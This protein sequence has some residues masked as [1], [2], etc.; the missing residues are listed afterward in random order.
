[1]RCT[2]KR[3]LFKNKQTID[4]NKQT[5]SKSLNSPAIYK[6]FPHGSDKMNTL[7]SC[8]DV[9]Q[10]LVKSGLHYYINESPH[11]IWITIRKKF[12]ND[13]HSLSISAPSENR[14]LN[15]DYSNLLE[16]Y[17][18]LEA[19]YD[20]LKNEFESEVGDHKETMDV[21]ERLT[22]QLT[23]KEQANLNLKQ[24]VKEIQ[25]NLDIIELNSKKSIKDFREKDKEIYNL[26]KENLKFRENIE[27]VEKDFRE[28]N[29]KVV[30]DEKES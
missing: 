26:K 18:Q 24:E 20:N 23:K 9:R 11:S 10:C 6:K 5:T 16:K 7:T 13:R 1:V 25:T 28:L 15:E 8:N 14:E 27:I 17:K 29:I 2:A 19:A 21:K 12:L 4:K 30:R 3:D 22:E